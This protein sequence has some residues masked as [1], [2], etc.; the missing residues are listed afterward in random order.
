MRR[1]LKEVL[2]FLNSG[3]IGRYKSE[4]GQGDVVELFD[5][6]KKTCRAHIKYINEY[7]LCVIIDKEFEE[8][9][10]SIANII[11]L[12]DSMYQGIL[13]ILEKLENG[14]LII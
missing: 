12:F 5:E 3:Q 14:Y 11:K 9:E 10:G 7:E 2:L 4:F 8:I 1:S 6:R 13:R